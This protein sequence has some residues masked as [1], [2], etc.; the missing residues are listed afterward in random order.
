MFVSR[1]ISSFVVFSWKCFHSGD[2][3]Y[4]EWSVGQLYVRNCNTF[5]DDDGGGRPE[6]DQD[7]S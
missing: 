7:R 4:T 1:K 5:D 3:W 6:D 2:A